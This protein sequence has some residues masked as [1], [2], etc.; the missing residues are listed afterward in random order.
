MLSCI[1]M[2]YNY[3]IQNWLS[4]VS[5]IYGASPVDFHQSKNNDCE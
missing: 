2:A 1:A 5:Q 4:L 3:M